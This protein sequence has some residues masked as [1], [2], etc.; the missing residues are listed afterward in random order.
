[1]AD[2]RAARS[3]RPVGCTGAPRRRR[4]DRDRRLELYA[5]MWWQ[6]ES[7]SLLCG[8]GRGSRKR[9][10]TDPRVGS[11]V[12]RSRRS[13]VSATQLDR[14]PLAAPHIP[15]ASDVYV[16]ARHI[17][18]PRVPAVLLR[19]VD[20]R[21]RRLSPCRGGRA[22]ARRHVAAVR[23][24]RRSPRRPPHGDHHRLRGHASLR[25]VPA[26]V[27]PSGASADRAHAARAIWPS[28]VGA[29]SRSCYAVACL[30]PAH[31]RDD[32]NDAWLVPEVRC[33]SVMLRTVVT[34]KG[35]FFVPVFRN[36]RRW[37][38]PRRF[39]QCVLKPLIAKICVLGD[40]QLEAGDVLFGELQQ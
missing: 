17:P 37:L 3:Q 11:R 34:A 32:C 40:D 18:A 25:S 24:S 7:V 10:P 8:Y 16:G 13:T 14:D 20:A 30:C 31:R 23:M 5:P 21:P 22:R 9:N 27:R 15:V 12:L 38:C 19:P 39:D 4:A 36:Q 35:S 2:S 6:G 33:S 1:M 26:R 29:A 28:S